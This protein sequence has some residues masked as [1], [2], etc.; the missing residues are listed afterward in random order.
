M[1]PTK[2]EVGRR[3]R[4]ARFRRNMTLKEVAARSGMSATHISEIERGKT[5]P[6]IGALQRISKALG[7]RPAYF[8]EERDSPLAILTRKDERAA[9][10]ICDTDG[11]V[12][13]MEKLSGNPPWTTVQLFRTVNEPGDHATRPARPGE[14]VILNVRGTT[15]VTIGDESH[16]LR[17]GDTIQFPPNMPYTIDVL[18]EDQSEL[19]GIGAFAST[20]SW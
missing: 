14:V 2:E 1:I 12:H 7:E 8:V 20:T 4:M 10:Y 11:H 18:G 3:V 19:L 5:S 16:V 15:R 6:T 9:V 13:T 17:E